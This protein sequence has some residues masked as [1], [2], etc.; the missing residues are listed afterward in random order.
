MFLFTIITL[1]FVPPVTVLLMALKDDSS[2]CER[3]ILES[4]MWSYNH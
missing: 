2:E 1:T 4:K 3:C